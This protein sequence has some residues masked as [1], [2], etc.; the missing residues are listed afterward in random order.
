LEVSSAYQCFTVQNGGE[1]FNVFNKDI[2]SIAFRA[3]VPKVSYATS[4]LGIC[5]HIYVTANLK[6]G[7]VKNNGRTSLSGDIFVLY[8]R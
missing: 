3:V 7:I 6:F 4:S 5:A 8:D 2:K 1:C